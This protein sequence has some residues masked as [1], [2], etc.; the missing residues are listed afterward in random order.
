MLPHFAVQKQKLV[1]C[2]TNYVKQDVKLVTMFKERNFKKIRFHLQE[3]SLYSMH[4]HGRNLVA[5]TGD[6]PP[7]FSTGGR[8]I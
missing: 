3:R 4:E 8:I 6:V 5:D 7:T 1:A 2:Q